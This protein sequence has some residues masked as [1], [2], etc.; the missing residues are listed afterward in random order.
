MNEAFNR[1]NPPPDWYP[2]MTPEETERAVRKDI[3]RQRYQKLERRQKSFVPRPSKYHAQMDM[4]TNLVKNDLTPET[5]EE[6]ARHFLTVTRNEEAKVKR[7]AGI[8]KRRRERR[9]QGKMAKLDD[10]LASVA[11]NKEGTRQEGQ[12]EGSS[13]DLDATGKDVEMAP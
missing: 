3:I 10:Q 12:M 9:H 11:I 1:S 4:M 6:I 8:Q 5:S 13:K 7:L 2:G